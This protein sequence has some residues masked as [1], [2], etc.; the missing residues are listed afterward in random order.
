MGL[1]EFEEIREFCKKKGIAISFYADGSYN[2]IG[3]N[4]LLF[5]DSDF[6]KLIRLSR[7]ELANKVIRLQ[8]LVQSKEA[9]KC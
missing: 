7:S 4:N 5:D 3:G 8:Q 1:I 9:E 2:Q 6:Q